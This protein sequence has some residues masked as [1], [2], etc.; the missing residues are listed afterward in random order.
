MKHSLWKQNTVFHFPRAYLFAWFLRICSYHF[1]LNLLSFSHFWPSFFLS[2]FFP[3]CQ[4][5]FVPSSPEIFEDDVHLHSFM[6]F[7]LLL[8]SVQIENEEF[9]QLQFL[10]RRSLN[11]IINKYLQWTTQLNWRSQSHYKF[12]IQQFSAYFMLLSGRFQTSND[13]L[14]TLKTNKTQ[15][16]N[17]NGQLMS[18]WP[19][20]TTTIHCLIKI[21]NTR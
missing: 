17:M 19:Q 15:R 7:P 9:Y 21:Y 1:A 12:E 6:P 14:K 10:M 13:H 5:S 11:L 18:T 4:T 20:C 2:L 3:I 8:S 16:H